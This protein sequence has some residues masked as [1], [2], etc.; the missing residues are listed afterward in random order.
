M[1]HGEKSN[2][3]D[4]IRQF[5]QMTKSENNDY[6]RAIEFATNIGRKEKLGKQN[7]AV[8]ATHLGLI[9]REL[10]YYDRS[11]VYHKKALEIQE[12]LEDRVGM[13]IVY[14]YMGIVYHINANWMMPYNTTRRLWRY[15]KRWE[16]GLR[17]PKPIATWGWYTTVKANR[18]MPCNTTRRLWRYNKHLKIGLVW[19]EPMATWEGIPQ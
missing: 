2:H 11:L 7:G 17:W 10:G 1:M 18:M 4:F 9:Y 19:Q 3:K 15:K 8:I 13:A 12:A 5:V 16:I 6:D 14:N